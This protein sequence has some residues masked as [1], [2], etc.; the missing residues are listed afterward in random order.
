MAKTTVI[1]HK[2]GFKTSFST[3]D[4]KSIVHSVQDVSKTIEYAKHIGENIT[5]SKSKDMRHIAEVPMVIYEKAM[6]EGWANDK[7][8]WKR[9]LDASENKCFRTWQG[10]V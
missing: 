8:K 9:W 4:N 5:L 3:E 10:K 1:N 6:L 2:Q 7:E